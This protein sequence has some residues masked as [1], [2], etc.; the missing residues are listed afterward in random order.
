MD[1]L[2]LSEPCGQNFARGSPLLAE[3]KNVSGPVVVSAGTPVASL[4]PPP[5][6][7]RCAWWGEASPNPTSKILP[8]VP[9]LWSKLQKFSHGPLPVASPC[10]VAP[11]QWGD[12]SVCE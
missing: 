4:P 2:G 8:W 7:R 3:S 1:K 12:T 9:L 10:A 6:A 11:D 5:Y